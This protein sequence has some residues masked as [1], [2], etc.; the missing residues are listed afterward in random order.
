[1]AKGLIDAINA[2]MTLISSFTEILNDKLYLVMIS[3]YFRLKELLQ[4][5]GRGMDHRHASV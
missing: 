5:V 1:M 4:D 2:K 3:I